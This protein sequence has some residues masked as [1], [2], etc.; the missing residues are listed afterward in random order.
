MITYFDIFAFGEQTHAPATL[1]FVG[2]GDF[3]R[4][5]L[6]HSTVPAH[7]LEGVSTCSA[8]YTS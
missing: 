3:S 4:T 8:M 6:Y 5:A 1:T 2:C 7:A